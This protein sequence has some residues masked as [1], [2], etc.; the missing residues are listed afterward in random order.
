MVQWANAAMIQF[1]N[2]TIVQSNTIAVLEICNMIL[3]L[4]FSPFY[5][6]ILELQHWNIAAFENGITEFDTETYVYQ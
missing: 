3:P 4:A 6:R 2:A 1:S 5:C